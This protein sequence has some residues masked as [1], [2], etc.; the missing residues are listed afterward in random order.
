MCMAPLPSKLFFCVNSPS[1]FRTR[2]FSYDRSFPHPVWVGSLFFIERTILVTVHSILFYL[3]SIK[4][5]RCIGHLFLLF[6][7]SPCWCT[8]LFHF[9]LALS[10]F[11]HSS[12]FFLHSQNCM[13]FLLSTM[14]VPPQNLLREFFFPSVRCVFCQ[15]LFAPEQTTR[16]HSLRNAARLTCA[17]FDYLTVIPAIS[18]KS[19]SNRVFETFLELNLENREDCLEPKLNF[20]EYLYNTH[21]YV[22][23]VHTKGWES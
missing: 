2:W 20:T 13:L 8:V 19:R 3:I 1:L 18:W 17:L 16:Y 14:S 10:F 22:I 7:P 11:I 12:I 23:F 4:G 15:A 21:K 9:Q 6:P 5:Q